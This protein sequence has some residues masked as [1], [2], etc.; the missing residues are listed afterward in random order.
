MNSIRCKPK[1][2]SR[3]YLFN[4]NSGEC[5]RIVCKSGYELDDEGKCVGTDI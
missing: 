4:F 3:G 5:E 1:E 2:C